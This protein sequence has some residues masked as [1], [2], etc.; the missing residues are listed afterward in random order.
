MMTRVHLVWL[1]ELGRGADHGGRV[2][3][4]RNL[5]KA[6]KGPSTPAEHYH[7][8]MAIVS[9]FDGVTPFSPDNPIKMATLINKEIGDVSGAK[10][11]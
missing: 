1:I 2:A 11:S 10:K 8:L 4:G 7:K 3:N 6:V 5:P 9:V